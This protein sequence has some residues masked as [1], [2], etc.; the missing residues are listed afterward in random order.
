MNQ[1]DLFDIVELL[2]KLPEYNL[3]VGSQG[4]IVECY[5]E[6]NYEVEFANK[7]GETITLCVL[8]PKQ[9]LT[10]WQAKTKSW[11]SLS[12]QITSIVKT[13]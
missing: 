9:F 13:L 4:T 11:L 7:E 3:D 8:S 2:V 5:D 10:V 6:N 1:P 12:E